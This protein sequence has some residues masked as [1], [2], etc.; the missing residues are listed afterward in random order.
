MPHS[1]RPWERMSTAAT[2]SATRAG[3]WKPGGISTTPKPSR[4][5][6]VIR[7]E[8]AEHHFVGR[9][10]RAT[11][12]EVVLDHPHRLEA[13]RVGEHDF[14]DGLF[15]RG[16]LGLALAV[17]MRLRPGLHLRLELIEQV[18]LHRSPRCRSHFVRPRRPY[19]PRSARSTCKASAV[20][21]SSRTRRHQTSRFVQGLDLRNLLVEHPCDDHKSPRHSP[22]TFG[23]LT[24]NR[25]QDV[26]ENDVEVVGD[27]VDRRDPGVNAIFDAVATSVLRSW[28]RTASGS[29]SIASTRVAPKSGRGHREHTAAAA[30]IEHRARC[31]GRA[32]ASA[33]ASAESTRARR[34]RTRAAGR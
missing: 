24:M 7:D 21:P 27:V 19:G 33:P 12:A 14:V 5:F 13:E 15:V 26:G 30:E 8:R 18:E 2:F 17:R 23:N 1:T 10:R 29:I 22:H 9:A 3:C 31:A 32:V 25:R 28:P 34:C 6:L 20:H 4:M 16:L 11:V